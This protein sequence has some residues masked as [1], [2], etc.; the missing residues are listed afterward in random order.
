MSRVS[1]R[2]EGLEGVL[3]TLR[4]LPPELVSKNGGPVRTAARKALVP[5][6]DDAKANVRAIV[7]EPNADGLP[8]D[9]TGLLE[10]SIGIKRGRLA[11]GKGE[12]LVLSPG[13]R[14]YPRT[15]KRGG[16][17]KNIT[18]GKVGGLLEFG[19]EKM[20][21]KPWMR[22]A[23]QKNAPKALQ[24]FSDEL[25]KGIAKIQRK[26]ERRNRVKK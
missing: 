18:T 14:K 23:Y 22:P 25:N 21:A 17:S 19:A 7:V 20:T 26:L 9:S 3:K 4:E 2:I 15:E 24:I 16:K 13:R 11:S 10:K 1:V 5:M 6:R 8:S 12:R